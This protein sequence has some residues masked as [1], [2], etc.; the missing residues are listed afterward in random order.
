VY[1]ADSASSQRAIVTLGGSTTSGFYQHFADGYTYP[2]WLNEMA[3]VAGFR[4]I[5]GGLGNYSSTQELLKLVTEVPRLKDDIALVI[6]LN[7]INDTPDY[8]GPDSERSAAYPFMTAV[9]NYMYVDQVWVDQRVYER[10]FLPN[11][12]SFVHFL[13]QRAIEQTRTPPDHAGQTVQPFKVIRAPQRWLLN[14][15]SMRAISASMGAEYV[16]FIQPTMG[17]AGV[18]SELPEKSTPDYALLAET[19]EQRDYVTQLNAFYDEIRALCS[20]LMY[21]FDISD[22]APPTGNNYS[23]PRHHNAKGNRILADAI[24]RRI[25]PLLKSDDHAGPSGTP[26]AAPEAPN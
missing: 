16:V 9:Q 1:Y 7:G 4:V 23:D 10:E 5:N 20:G 25:A 15:Q 14:V 22:V 8:Q 18:Q 3:S 26:P 11:I 17:L 19:L 2:Y 24:F 6:S 12:M 21:C 13:G